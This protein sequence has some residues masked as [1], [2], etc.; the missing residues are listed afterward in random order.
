MRKAALILTAIAAIISGC[1]DNSGVRGYWSSRALS[2]EDYPAAEEEFANFAELAVQAPEAD[3][4]A[5]VDML[6]DKA[7]KD[8]VTYLVYSDLILRAFGLLASPC[9]SGP[10]F[11][12]AADKILSQGVVD[13]Y[14][15]NQ[16]EKRREFLLH[17]KVGDKAEIPE[18]LD[19]NDQ[20]FQF[21]LV[22]RTLFLVVD[23]ACPS[24][25]AAMSHFFST[26]WKDD[27]LV[28]LC[29]GKGPLP[30]EPGW[31]CYRLPYSQTIFDTH[32]AP[33]FFVTAPDG[34]VEKSYTS[35]HDDSIL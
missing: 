32:E 19:V 14:T 4:F 23:Q 5:A 33:F 21:P 28:A 1:R 27:W 25:T 9:Y 26:E 16:F 7:S 3:A 15:A 35:A 22:Q 12:H 17:N 10:I 20:S 18:L 24:C 6:L 34:T 30:I 11:I 29:C 31:D 13:A 2:I 8:E